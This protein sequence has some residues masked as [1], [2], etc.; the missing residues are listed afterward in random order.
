MLELNDLPKAD[1]AGMD[2]EL[3]DLS[4]NNKNSRL[5]Q[6]YFTLGKL[7]LDLGF[8]SVRHGAVRWRSFTWLHKA[9]F[10]I[11]SAAPLRQLF[12]YKR[13]AV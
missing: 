11:K 3:R 4:R 12:G 9:A 8:Y 10:L 5:D 1:W 7:F 6:V 13:R 2:L